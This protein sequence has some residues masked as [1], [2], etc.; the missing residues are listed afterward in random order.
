MVDRMQEIGLHPYR[1]H[2]AIRRLPGCRECIGHKCPRECKL[3][4]RSAGIEPALATGRA[5][6]LGGAT[7]RALRGEADRITHIEVERDGRRFDLRARA[8]VLA[9][10][11]L[12]SP[13]LLLASAS[14]IWPQGCANAS[15]LVGRGL[16]FHLGEGFALWPPRSADGRGP[17]KTLSLRDFYS[18]DGKRLGLVQSLGLS[19]GYGNIIQVLREAY[20]RSFMSRF[21]LGREALRIP[22]RLAAMMLGEARIFVG[23]LEDLPVDSNRVMFDPEQRDSFVVEYRITPE[24]AERRAL[25]RRTIRRGMRGLRLLFLNWSPELNLAHPCGT[26]RF[27]DDSQRGVLDR[28]C[29]AHGIDNLYVADSSFM[30]TSTGVNLCLTI[31]ANALRVADVLAK[32][33]QMNESCPIETEAC[34]DHRYEH[35]A[36]SPS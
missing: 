20:S 12:G 30:P 19:A 1:T 16:M 3:D 24:L 34:A 11:G 7:V 32:R 27:S 4:G 31:T 18:A 21:R 26:L 5:A 33:L 13:H 10:G 17:R 35:G 2:L 22:A 23:I 9:A 8:Y 6:F 25:F 14:E 36:T 29:K 15:G 28:N